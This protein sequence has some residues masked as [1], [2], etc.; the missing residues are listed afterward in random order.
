MISVKKRCCE[1]EMKRVRTIILC[2][3]LVQ[4]YGLCMNGGK[5]MV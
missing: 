5:L 4:S 2:L 3:F 1:R